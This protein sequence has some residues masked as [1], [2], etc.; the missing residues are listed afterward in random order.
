[1]TARQPRRARRRAA[2]AASLPRPLAGDS[3][4]A[5]AD[6]HRGISSGSRRI[7]ARAREHHVQEDYSHVKRDLVAVAVVSAATIGFVVVMSFFV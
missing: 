5:Q 7:A 4:A 6:Q 1:M 3:I 2:P